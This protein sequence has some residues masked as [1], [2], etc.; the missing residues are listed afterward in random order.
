MPEGDKIVTYA[1]F[2]EVFGLRYTKD[3]IRR[4]VEKGGFPKPSLRLSPRL[5][6]W[7]VREIIE[8][9]DQKAA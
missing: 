2:R 9:I 1:D 7:R 6:A 3:H 4:L 8:W 5:N